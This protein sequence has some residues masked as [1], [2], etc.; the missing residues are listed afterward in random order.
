[1]VHELCDLD[2][3]AQKDKSEN[4]KEAVKLVTCSKK[5]PQCLHI[6]AKAPCT[7]HW[8]KILVTNQM[9]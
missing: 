9:A 8:S 6:P 1:M 3:Y 2:A 4:G 7:I 5:E